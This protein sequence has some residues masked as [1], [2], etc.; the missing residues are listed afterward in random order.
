VEEIV[1]SEAMELERLCGSG[2][3]RLK[4]RDSPQG[5]RRS[6]DSIRID[7]GAPA[8]KARFLH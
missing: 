1:E 4:E 3:I 7:D 8:S 5:T 6:G 2:V